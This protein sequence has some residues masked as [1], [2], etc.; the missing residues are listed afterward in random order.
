MTHVRSCIP[1]ALD[2]QLLG[3]RAPRRPRAPGPPQRPSEPALST[4]IP[5]DVE[6]FDEPSR[7]KAFPFDAAAAAAETRTRQHYEGSLRRGSTTDHPPFLDASPRD[8][9]ASLF[10][11]KNV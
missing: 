9:F 10:C 6:P 3:T 2:D 4:T 11:H 7:P 8:L 1:R 5:S